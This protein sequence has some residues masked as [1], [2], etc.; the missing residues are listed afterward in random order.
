M[1]IATRRVI[2]DSH[3]N[4]LHSLADKCH[5]EKYEPIHVPEI[6]KSE[7]KSGLFTLNR[8]NAVVSDGIIIDMLE[9]LDVFRMDNITDIISGIY[10]SGDILEDLS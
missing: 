6:L 2:F 10:R 5:W 3:S 8:H 4:L 9:A 7:V 1:W